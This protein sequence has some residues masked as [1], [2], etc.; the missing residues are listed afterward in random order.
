MKRFLI[1]ILVILLASFVI[2][3]LAYLSY[4]PDDNCTKMKLYT[5]RYN[6]VSKKLGMTY[7]E[8]ERLNAFEVL[9]LLKKDTEYGY[10]K[11]SYDL[12]KEEEINCITYG[13]MSKWERF[14]IDVYS[15]EFFD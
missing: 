13:G 10:I 1:V 11:A 14:Q 3:G 2:S 4:T 6:E 8:Y 12:A 15:G 9:R 7:S 5:E